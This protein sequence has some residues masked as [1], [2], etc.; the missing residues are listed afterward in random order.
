MSVQLQIGFLIGLFAFGVL[1]RRRGWLG[2]P[3]A[4]RMLQL[5]MTVGLPALF[6]ANVS[7]IPL[8]AELV[9]LPLSAIFIMM[10]T[11]GAAFLAGRRLGLQRVSMG[12]FIICGMS[13]NASFMFPF[14]LAGWGREAFAQLA[15]FD[16]GNALIQSTVLYAAGAI[17]GGHAVGGKAIL[18]RVLGFPPLWGLVVALAINVSGHRLPTVVTDVVGFAGRSILL[19]SILSVGILFDARLVRSATV[20][21][22]AAMRVLLGFALALLFVTVFDITGMTR[23]VILLSGAAPIGFSV[24]VIANRE[25]LDRELAASAASLSALFALAYVPLGLWLLNPGP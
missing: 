23:A 8:R 4:G 18:K 12:A 1:S 25:S 9:A 17:Y 2:P 21:L 19:L 3:H 24:M 15:L 7:R 11:L 14:L 6:I 5:V 13:I 10:T 16:L 22:A 20:F